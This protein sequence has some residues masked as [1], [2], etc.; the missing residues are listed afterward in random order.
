MKLFDTGLD[1]LTCSPFPIPTAN[2]NA[3]HFALAAAL[4]H[5]TKNDTLAK[6][7]AS[8]YELMTKIGLID[9]KFNVFDGIRDDCKAVN[10][11]Q[12][13]QNAGL[14]LTGSAYMLQQVR[15]VL[16]VFLISS[17]SSI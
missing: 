3:G 8:G 9:D 17:I 12:F 14:L 2:S 7:A 1:L 16:F 11:Q 13:S 4:A 15:F 10:Q 6:Q 5:E